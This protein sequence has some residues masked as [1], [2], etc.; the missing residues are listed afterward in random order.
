MTLQNSLRLFTGALS[1]GAGL[2]LAAGAAAQIPPDW[3][4]L[5]MF[6]NSAPVT[7]NWVTFGWGNANVDGA[8]TTATYGQT[9]TAPSVRPSDRRTYLEEWTFYL[10][11]V[12]VYAGGLDTEQSFEFFVMAWDPATGAATGPVLYHSRRMTVAADVTSYT[13]FTICPDDLALTPG[14]QYVILINVSLERN[15]NNPDGSSLELAGNGSGGLFYPPT[16]AS[17]LGGQF[18][19]QYT[20]GQFRSIDQLDAALTSQPWYTWAVNEYA[21][22]D[23]VFSDDQTH[24]H[25]R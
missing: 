3:R 10:Q 25:R 15:D 2:L 17:P 7:G 1:A 20:T 5:A 24:H 14:S 9:F 4:G 13:P 12:P 8:E 18:V 6:D 11:Q 19:Y 21:A 16:A 23:A 22:Y